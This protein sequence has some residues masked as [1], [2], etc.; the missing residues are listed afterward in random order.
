MIILTWLFCCQIG[1]ACDCGEFKQVQKTA[2]KENKLILVHFSNFYA[3]DDKGNPIINPIQ[4][5]QDLSALMDNY[6]YVCVNQFHNSAWLKKFKFTSFPQLLLVDGNGKEVYRFKDLANGQEFF[7]A[8]QNFSFSRNFFVCERQNFSK[9]KSY[10][11]ALRVAQK[12]LD[13]SLVVDQRFK[14]SVFEV[15]QLYILEAENALSKRDPARAEKL[16]K[17]ELLKLFHWAY[18]RNFSFL[19]QKLSGLNTAELFESNANLFY[20]LK[21]ITSKALQQEDFPQLE[22]K[23]KTID[24]F[25]NFVKKAELILT[26]QA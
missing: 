25:E 18:E 13:Y 19:N 22:A 3:E 15:G 21:Y 1:F 6:V 8:L 23:V 17:I 16:Q 26:Q 14:K 12:Y 4:E 7:D 20:F 9:D 5:S 11:T 24:G 10:P 2:L